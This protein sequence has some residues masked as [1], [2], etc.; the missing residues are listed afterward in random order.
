MCETWSKPEWCEM[1][2][3]CHVTLTYLFTA[4][5]T[6]PTKIVFFRYVLS[7]CVKIV[8]N[9][10]QHAFSVITHFTTI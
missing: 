4:V 1:F 9:I 6:S 2:L 3:W 7:I 8:Q 5:V 10:M